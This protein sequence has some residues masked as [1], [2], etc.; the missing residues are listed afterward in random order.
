MRLRELTT[1]ALLGTERQ[2]APAVTGEDEKSR[3]LRQL[4]WTQREPALLSAAA[5]AAVAERAGA[6]PARNPQ[7][8][9]PACAAE[10]LPWLSPAAASLM[11]RLLGGEQ[12]QLLPECLALILGAGRVVPPEWLPRLLAHGQSQRDLREPIRAVLGRRGQWL[13]AQHPDWSWAGGDAEVPDAWQTGDPATRLRVLQQALRTR[14]EAARTLLQSTWQEETPE[15]R[16]RFAAALGENLGPGDEPFL[17]TLL[18]DKR[19]EVRRVAADLLARLE[20]SGLGRRMWERVQPLLQYRSAEAGSLLRLR[21]GKPATLEVAL[22]AECTR[23]MQRDGLEV[24]PPRG[25]GE[26]AWWLQQMLQCIPPRRWTET[27]Q[28]TP[29]QILALLADTDFADPLREGLI[30]A[31]LTHREVAWA[32]EL[33]RW[34]LAHGR[35][36]PESSPALLHLLP[37]GERGRILA[38]VLREQVADPGLCL[39]L[40]QPGS[41]TDEGWDPPTSRVVLQWLRATTQNPSVDWS[42]RAQLPG[43][44]PRLAPAV[45]PE[46]LPGWPAEGPAA[47]QWAKGVNDFLSAVQFRM[48]LHALLS[49]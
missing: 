33:L 47:E 34:Q 28:A 15:D 22:P 23:E 39:A 48:E 32:R 9:P 7:A 5:L 14:P 29:E 25:M 12:A 46:A 37:E 11:G 24:K 26:K 36:T 10:D 31:T 45:L 8:P 40:L 21:K 38:Q 20:D 49:A 2:A 17:E 19:K 6:R 43:L 30:R 13:A 41:A 1:V 35:I 3:L 4:D 18:E 16:A 27:W 42:V 44:A